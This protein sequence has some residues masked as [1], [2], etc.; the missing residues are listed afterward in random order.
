MFSES[1]AGPPRARAQLGRA[2]RAGWPATAREQG[3]AQAVAL[4]VA[5]DAA[6]AFALHERLAAEH[7]R[8]LVA[9]KLGPYHAFIAGD[10]PGLLRLA[11]QARAGA[12]DADRRPL[13]R[14]PRFP[15]ARR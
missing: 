12:S 10:S 6:A 14:G 15:A 7:P 3:F 2:R 9:L 8:D 1:P 5:G 13:H 4:W 11:W